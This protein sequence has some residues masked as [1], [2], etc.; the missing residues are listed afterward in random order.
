MNS[1]RISAHNIH[2]WIFETLHIVEDD[3]KVLQ[4]DGPRRK[5][6]IKF[7]T[8]KMMEY[9]NLQQGY[10]DCTHDTGEVTQVQVSPIGLGHRT[11]RVANLHPETSDTAIRTAI[12]YYGDVKSITDEQ[13]SPT[14]RYEVA[15]GMRYVNIILKRQI[16][17]R[18]TVHGLRA[19]ITYEGQPTTCFTCAETGHQAGDCPYKRTAFPKPKRPTIGT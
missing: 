18:I 3:I 11:V 4:I 13:W 17:S 6:Y 8:G 1:P 15:N 7:K 5:V 9:T 12:E 10:Y 16:T 2:E 19:D 14:Y